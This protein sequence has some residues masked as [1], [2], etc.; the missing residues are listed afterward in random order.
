[1]WSF[2]LDER[3]RTVLAWI[4]GGIVAVATGVWALVKFVLSERKEKRAR[5][6][7][8]KAS[9]GGVAAGRD[10]KNNKITT[11]GGTKS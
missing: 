3:N 5:A 1:M 10:I 8:V 9:Q 7:I 11:R 4:G 2:L 6:P